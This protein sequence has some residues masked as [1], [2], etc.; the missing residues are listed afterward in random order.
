MRRKHVLQ[1]SAALFIAITAGLLV[2]DYLDSCSEAALDA[3]LDGGHLRLRSNCQLLLESEKQIT[4]EVTIEGGRLQAINSRIFHVTENA[5]LTLRDTYLIGG[6]ASPD[7]G[8][9]ILNNGS[10]HLNNVQFLSN[11]AEEGG[12]IY[13]SG[14]LHAV[15]TRFARNQATLGGAVMVTGG[16]AIFETVLFEDN[17]ARLYGGALYNQDA[18]VSLAQSRI[19][20]SI[21]PSSAGVANRGDL[22][23]THSIINRNIA[24]RGDSGGIANGPDGTVTISHSTIANNQAVGNAGGIGNIGT[25]SLDHVALEA[26]RAGKVA[27]GLYNYYSARASIENSSI[28][29]NTDQHGAQ[30]SGIV[31]YTERDPAGQVTA[32]RNYWGAIDGPSGEGNGSGDGVFGMTQEDYTPWLEHNPLAD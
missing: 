18:S 23:I 3:V 16:S 32:T 21:A 25:L 8:G 24:Q 10:L 11:S 7:N 22:T 20:R 9:A 15:A 27:G 19:L 31:N 26:N 13:S 17:V 1:V 29:S 30:R 14:G 12:A 28:L 6:T 2:R 5:Q 4:G